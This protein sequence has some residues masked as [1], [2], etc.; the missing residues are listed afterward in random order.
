MR[1]KRRAGVEWCGLPIVLVS[2]V[3]RDSVPVCSSTRPLLLKGA[4]TIVTPS[5][6]APARLMNVPWLLKSLGKPA[7]E[8]SLFPSRRSEEHTSEL[9]S[10]AFIVCRLLLE[11]KQVAAAALLVVGA[12]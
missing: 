9:Q 11:K 4:P 12:R 8:K 1:D 5:P 3:S 7:P 6:L 2:L 10:L